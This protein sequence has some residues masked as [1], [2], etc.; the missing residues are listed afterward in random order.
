M[1]ERV[2][3]SAQVGGSGGDDVDGEGLLDGE[4]SWSICSGHSEASGGRA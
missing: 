4:R 1:Q 3:V 2:V